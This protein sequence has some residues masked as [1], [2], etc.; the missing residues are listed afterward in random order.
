MGMKDFGFVAAKNVLVN[1]A[2]VISS[3]GGDLDML[4]EFR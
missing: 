4:V 1:M 2:Q 3:A